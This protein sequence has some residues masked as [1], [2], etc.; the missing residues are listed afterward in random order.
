MTGPLSEFIDKL[1]SALRPRGRKLL[2]ET[3][4][5][6]SQL[7]ALDP[8][9]IHDMI[10]SIVLE[11]FESVRGTRSA[12]SLA[13]AIEEAIISFRIPGSAHAILELGR[14]AA[15][16]VARGDVKPREAYKLLVDAYQQ[17]KLDFESSMEAVAGEVERLLGIAGPSTVATINYATTLLR[18]FLTGRSSI[19]KL[20]V[21][22]LAP[23]YSGR[24]LAVTLRK[25]KLNS[26]YLPDTHVSWAARQ[27][28]AVV[29]YA[30][31]GSEGYV[32][33]DMGSYT[34]AAAAKA[35]E[36]PVIVVAPHFNFYGADETLDLSDYKV[37]LNGYGSLYGVDADPIEILD[38]DLI[39]HLVAGST[40]YSPPSRGDILALASSLKEKVLR[41]IYID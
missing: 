34:L 40:V 20:L 29:I 37:S 6:K 19:A 15:G 36:V 38:F 25:E 26:Y 10:A 3:A 31:G 8:D 16:L 5:I 14:H 2:E 1:S 4:N 21:L 39:D 35:Y 12:S 33:G 32:L 22:D 9:V 13:T 18:V 41:L 23:I 28:D 27:S 24:R 30:L 7:H 11:E 17:F